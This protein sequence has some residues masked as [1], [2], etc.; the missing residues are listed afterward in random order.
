MGTYI[1]FTPD[2][3]GA[4]VA[5]SCEGLVPCMGDDHTMLSQDPQLTPA[6]AVEEEPATASGHMHERSRS[7]SQPCQPSGAL[8]VVHVW[9]F[10]PRHSPAIPKAKEL[11]V[12]GDVT[13]LKLA[14][15][16]FIVSFPLRVCV[17]CVVT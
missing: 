3:T 12:L 14:S 13:L 5:T 2:C 8:S 15:R 11:S 17:N 4:L 9:L 16:C 7:L 1:A 6:T 10:L